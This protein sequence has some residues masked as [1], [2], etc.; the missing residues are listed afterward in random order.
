M[1]V[2]S[3]LRKDIR[4]AEPL[5]PMIDVVFFLIIFFMMVSHF[6]DPEPFA[7]ARPASTARRKRP[8]GLNFPRSKRMAGMRSGAHAP[9]SRSAFV[10]LTI[11]SRRGPSKPKMVRMI[12]RKVMSC[13]G[14]WNANARR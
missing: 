10:F 14:S 6:A 13:I 5:L 7:V 12:T 11:S 8:Y 4:Q 2:T 1:R 9:S 3:P